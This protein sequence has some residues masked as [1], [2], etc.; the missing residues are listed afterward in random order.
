MSP[1][2]TNESVQ[3]TQGTLDGILAKDEIGLPAA[4]LSDSAI[5][6]LK[7]RYLIPTETPRQLFTRIA[8]AVAAAQKKWNNDADVEKTA[9]VL[10]ELMAS[11]K[12][13]PNSP[14]L[15]N[16]GKP[17]GQ[18]SAC[19]VLPIKDDLE[20]IFETLKQTAMIQTSGGGTGFSFGQLRAKG[21]PIANLVGKASGPLDFIKVFDSVTGVIKQ[22]ATRRGANMAI[23]PCDAPDIETFIDSKTNGGIENFNISVS[24]TD[25]FMEAVKNS[26]SWNLINPTDRRIVKTISAKKLWRKMINAA[27]S[28]GDPGL[29]FMDQ[30][31]KNNPTPDLGPMESTNPCGEQPLLAFE[32]CNLGSMNLLAYAG[33]KNLNW[34]SLKEDIFS[35]VRFLDNVI[36]T[37][38]YPVTEI[39]KITRRNRKIGLGVM[40]WA[41][42][43]IR[44]KIPYES[45]KAIALAKETMK[46]INLYA[47]ETSEALAKERG[48]FAGF[49][50]SIWKEKG[51]HP[52]RNATVTTIA[53]TGTISIIANVSSGIEPLFSLA[54]ER[55]ALDGQKLVFIH[56]E[57]RKI[58]KEYKI[59]SKKAVIQIL[60]TGSVQKIAEIPKEIR[61]VFKTAAE[62]SSLQHLKMQAAFQEHTENAVS[63]TINLPHFAK[64]SEVAKIY[65]TAFELGCKGITVFR[66]HSKTTQV[67]VRGT[68]KNKKL[69]LDT[70]DWLLDEP[71]NKADIKRKAGI[72]L[73][74]LSRQKIRQHKQKKN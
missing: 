33:T 47:R 16:A 59:K 37:N 26:D 56:P 51:F 20:S 46:K 65:K 66:D 14:T 41:D 73:A 63:K 49:K 62:I 71:E 21:E 53:P 45:P 1:L 15:M 24:V 12:F 50:T 6:V 60:E 4:E 2:P 31:N 39:E 30:I 5:R 28:C 54:Y 17:K 7:A 13:L 32:S 34:N 42:C 8:R 64:P 29:V 74:R 55:E 68:G 10:F 67:L 3:N 40:G 18:L 52:R 23:L 44:W 25:A 38:F 35:A 57:I 19:F 36:E 58:L 72:D 9:K 11:L 48:E 70:V 69:L 43:L 22:G 61:N 27:W